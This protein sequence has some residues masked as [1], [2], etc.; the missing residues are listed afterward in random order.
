MFKGFGGSS[1]VC[2]ENIS[3]QMELLNYVI[4][5]PNINDVDTSKRILHDSIKIRFGFELTDDQLDVLTKYDVE[6]L[7]DFINEL[8]EIVRVQRELQFQKKK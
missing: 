1:F 2:I 7:E 4:Y 3:D 5:N 6:H 8:K